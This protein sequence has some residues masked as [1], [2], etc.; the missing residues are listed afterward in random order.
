MAEKFNPYRAWLELDVADRPRSH[1]ELF[2]LQ[3]GESDPQ[4]IAAAA[5]QAMA[6]VRRARP[7]PH[8]A[9]WGRLLDQLEA[10]KTCLLDPASKAAYD[11]SL[12]GAK[13][14]DAGPGGGSSQGSGRGASDRGKTG[15]VAASEA[16]RQGVA[17]AGPGSKSS[18]APRGREPSSAA[19]TSS[20]PPPLRPWE[21]LAAPETPDQPSGPSEDDLRLE[22]PTAGA[23]AGDAFVGEHP[24]QSLGAET[25]DQRRTGH[26]QN[27][28]GGRLPTAAP[29]P[30]SAGDWQDE[31]DAGITVAA[32]P[33]RSS[34]VA[35]DRRE[36][37]QS[38]KTILATL[39]LVLAGV[40]LGALLF[41]ALTDDDDANEPLAPTEV[42]GNTETGS[43][44]A[45]AGLPSEDTTEG[46]AGAGEG[47]NLPGSGVATEPD[48]AIPRPPD[49]SSDEP[50]PSGAATAAV[51]AGDV[52]EGRLPAGPTRDGS[53]DARSAGDAQP[54]EE[55]SISGSPTSPTLTDDDPTQ[56]DDPTVQ[57][58]VPGPSELP[59]TGPNR[60]AATRP[61]GESPRVPGQPDGSSQPDGTTP[62]VPPRA[63]AGGRAADDPVD[64]LR[65]GAFRKAIEKA[66]DAIAGRDPVA[67]GEHLD[68]AKALAATREESNLVAQV[69]TVQLNLMEFF[70]GCTQA[71]AAL[72]SGREFIVDGRRIVV[73]EVMPGGIKL[74]TAGQTRGFAFRTCPRWVVEMIAGSWFEDQPATKL[75]LGTFLA[76]DEVGK[77]DVAR[78]K[79]LW[80]EAEKAGLPVKQLRAELEHVERRRQKDRR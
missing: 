26:N 51:P 56:D 77:P 36:R 66:R 79:R 50:D 16:G 8:A 75:L 22:T 47:A 2:G 49:S 44:N 57:A 5:D 37:R 27:G 46:T 12:P 64:P 42:A 31:P 10:A 63:N 70:K 73:I 41:A 25:R 80:A 7:G 24:E 3:P 13:A 39:A 35:N 55:R 62:S 32:P 18:A 54:N 60:G 17:S 34:V 29:I 68:R 1:Y 33:G 52:A 78:A 76:F 72:E 71:A 61:Q 15:R 53:A 6:K 48:H 4:R 59:H 45:E 21:R 40:G 38:L 19:S 11:A 65:P 67:A 20:S 14:A 69:R 23:A 9:Q 28:G 58:T 74:R 30:P 43:D